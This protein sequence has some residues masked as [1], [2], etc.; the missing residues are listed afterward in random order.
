MSVLL[1]TLA[2]F[3]NGLL[4]SCQLAA[5]VYP[6]PCLPPYT[7]THCPILQVNTSV[8]T[9]DVACWQQAEDEAQKGLM[10]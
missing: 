5:Y 8:T 10:P 1:I 7:P 4:A 3:A 2:G 9:T 6:T